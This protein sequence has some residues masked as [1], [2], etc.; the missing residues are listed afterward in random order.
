MS[1]TVA[2]VFYMG[3]SMC[4]RFGRW[5]GCHFE[6]RYD[7]GA[8][9]IADAVPDYKG[10]SGGD[11]AIMETFRAKT[12]VRDVCTRCGHAIERQGGPK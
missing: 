5:R 2:P 10:P 12:Y 1:A 6:A 3:T 4:K 8:A 9:Q 7:L 11:G